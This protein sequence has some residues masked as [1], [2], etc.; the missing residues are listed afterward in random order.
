MNARC[1]VVVYRAVDTP[2]R[3][4]RSRQN[5]P[6]ELCLT[7]VQVAHGDRGTSTRLP[8]WS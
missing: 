4:A 1:M 3:S 5:L 7:R 8:G 2:P 6:P